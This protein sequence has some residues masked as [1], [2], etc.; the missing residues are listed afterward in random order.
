M[1]VNQKPSMKP[2]KK[3]LF[4]RPLLATA[5]GIAGLLCMAASCQSFI[6]TTEKTEYALAQAAD[7]GMK[8]WATY[9]K[10]ATNNPAAINRTLA[11]I[12][13]ELGQAAVEIQSL[14]GMR[15][16]SHTVEIYQVQIGWFIES[17]KTL[18]GG[19]VQYLKGSVTKEILK[20]S[21]GPHA[22]KRR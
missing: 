13:N 22:L 4:K 15:A 12:E 18:L 20:N 1:F 19:A 9:Y 2:T 17:C 8:S 10:A 11:G 5:I 6:N 7:A 16:R 3:P 14:F 21:V